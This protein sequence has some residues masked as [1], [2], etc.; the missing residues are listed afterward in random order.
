[1]SRH[2]KNKTKDITAAD[3]A[4]MDDSLEKFDKAF[5]RHIAPVMPSK[6]KTMKYHK[7]SHVTSS[8]RRLGSTR[9]FDAQFYEASNKQQKAS[10][11]TT[12]KKMTDGKYLHE[13]ALHQK[14]TQA[15]CATSTFD[16]DKEV[17]RR[18]SAFL[19]ASRTGENAMASKTFIVL[20]I[21]DTDE[22]PARV[23]NFMESMGDFDKIREAVNA[24][25]DCPPSSVHVRRTAVLSACVPWLSDEN[26]LQTIRAAP[27]F[28]GRPYHDSVMY[29]TAESAVK[30]YG[31][32]RLIF[33]ARD[34]ATNA[35]L[36]LVC[37][38]AYAVAPR[39][40]TDVLVK[41]G[42]VALTNTSQYAVVPLTCLLQ[43]IYVVP[44]FQRGVSHF[45]LCKWKWN[46]SP[47][48]DY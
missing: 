43:R 7:L 5:R 3:L 23:K 20:P 24:H 35:N 37:I 33:M 8:I 18:T 40:Q 13:M 12:S 25:F 11:N 16:P 45:H 36:E 41:A 34:I 1:M 22:V 17:S 29:R 14:T 38:R 2:R 4:E 32:V 44:D 28:H 48:Q 15:M 27:M 26:E 21:S 30:R 47:I 9:E 42:C 39:S 46:R 6:G 10:Y 31:T 19:T